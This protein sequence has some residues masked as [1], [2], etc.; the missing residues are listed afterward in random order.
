MAYFQGPD[1]LSLA[2]LKLV[3]VKKLTS[4]QAYPK[5]LK[6]STTLKKWPIAKMMED[7]KKFPDWRLIH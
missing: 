1:K 5:K 3:I 4:K 2:K 7:G 6:F